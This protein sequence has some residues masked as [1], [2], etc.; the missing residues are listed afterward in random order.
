MK[1]FATVFFYLGTFA[2]SFGSLL[3]VMCVPAF[4]L[5]SGYLA[6][7]IG[8][9]IGIHRFSGIAAIA[10]FSPHIDK[11]NS[12]KIIYLTEI[13]AAVASI[14]LLAAW[15]YREEFGLSIFLAFIGVRAISVGVQSTSR[16]RLIKLLSSDNLS[17]EASFAIWLNKVTQGAHVLSALAA[18]PLVA[19]GNLYMAIAIDCLTFLVGGGSAMLLPDIDSE[20]EEKINIK[21]TNFITTISAF[22]KMHKTVFIQDMLLAVSV[23]GTIL[24]MVKLSAGNS[25]Y[26]IYFNLI[27][28]ICIW[29]SSIFAHNIKLRNYTAVYWVA[30]MVGYVLL[31]FYYN[32]GFRFVAYFIAY[33]GYWILYHKYTVEIQTKTPKDLI[34]ATMAARGLVIAATLSVGELFGGYISRLIDIEFEL[35]LRAAICFFVLCGL[36]LLRHQTEKYKVIHDGI[37]LENRTNDHDR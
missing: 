3:F 1:K 12:K 32:S 24:L 18:I 9:A 19:T 15:Y 28:G 13:F 6:E 11:F 26:V 2:T 31:I 10:W 27:F 25:E 5:K 14:V 17:R 22:F 33:M 35:G 4:F 8:I 23:S 36:W 20:S 29:L 37:S 16:N 30:I 34:G 7:T 21:R